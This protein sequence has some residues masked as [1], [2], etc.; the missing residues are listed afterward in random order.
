MY[1]VGRLAKKFGLSRTALLYYDRIGL[2]SPSGHSPAGYRLYGE[3]DTRRL[4]QICTFRRAGLRLDDI[5]RILDAPETDLAA[6]LEKRLLELNEEIEDLRAQQRLIVGL[7]RSDHLRDRVGVMNRQTW[8]SLLSA[9]G[10][11]VEDMRQW[12]VA[13][14]RHAPDK[15]QR[16]LEFLCV[17]DDEI[18]IIRSWA[19]ARDNS[20]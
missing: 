14:E 19:A 9:S 1:T 12:H 10:F 18:E 20:G 13:F 2:L 17:P 11:S 4:E 15:H 16:F 6:V 7:L 3:D 8:V 5:S